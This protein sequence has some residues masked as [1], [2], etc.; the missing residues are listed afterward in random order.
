MIV[1]LKW[2]ESLPADIRDIIQNKV[3]PQCQKYGNDETSRRDREALEAMQ[4]APYNVQVHLI[5]DNELE[6][7]ANY[8]N[9]RE[10]GIK[11]YISVVGPEGQKL[12]DEVKRIRAELEK[13][14]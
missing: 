14:K 2:W 9:V 6:T 5:P 13:K 7:W 1:N 12:V 3:F 11:K 10:E 8:N 4:K